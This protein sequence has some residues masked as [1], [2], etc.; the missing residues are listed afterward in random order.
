MM[1]HR[2]CCVCAEIVIPKSKV[3]QAR[4]PRGLRRAHL[5]SIRSLSLSF[6]SVLS[7]P[8]SWPRRSA[9][10]RSVAERGCRGRLRLL[11]LRI[12]V[13]VLLRAVHG[14]AHASLLPAELR[15]RRRGPLKFL[16]RR[17]EARCDVER[18]LVRVRVERHE[19][20]R[21]VGPEHLLPVARSAE[22]EGPRLGLF[23]LVHL[24]RGH[25]V[26]DEVG[27]HD[28]EA[29]ERDGEAGVDDDDDEG[30]HRPH[31][32]ARCIR[33]E[34]K[35]EPRHEDGN[36]VEGGGQEG[37]KDEEAEKLIVVRPHAVVDPHAVVVHL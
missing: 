17:E 13:R 2:L 10:R 11:L 35:A 4:S 33:A 24:D 7:V 27:V 23:L 5:F 22:V 19:P 29:D 32:R 37:V 1:I 26:L 3:V 16:L 9:Q 18:T 34:V 14:R 12:L 30:E 6:S 15:H 8:H 25:V 20:V 28:E 31:A 36:G 21:G